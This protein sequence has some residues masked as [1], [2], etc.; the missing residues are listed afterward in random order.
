MKKKATI[1]FF[2]A[3][4]SLSPVF[5]QN[6]GKN[7]EPI[8]FRGV[9]FDA[10]T[11]NTLV[12]SQIYLNRSFSAITGED[13]TFSIYA[14]RNDTIVFSILGYKPYPLIVSD[15]LKGKEF[16]TGVYLQSDTLEIGEVIIVPR[17][18]SLKADIMNPMIESNTQLDNARTNLSI[19]SFQGKTAQGRMGDPNINYEYIRQ[20]QKINAYER[21]GIPSD[22]ILGISPLLIIPVAYRL[23]HGLPDKPVPPKPQISS[24]ELKELNKKY[25]ESIRNRK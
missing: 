15:T 24:K 11:R 2:A 3:C 20:K 5:S 6:E 7:S 14:H 9:V 19:A 16:L 13:G 21:G 12:N 10:S 17:L 18:T 23:L 1:I 22:K 4:F 8:L 25:L